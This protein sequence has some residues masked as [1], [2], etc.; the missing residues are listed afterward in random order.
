MSGRAAT[1]GDQRQ[2]GPGSGGASR[3]TPNRSRNGSLVTIKYWEV[4]NHHQL[5]KSDPF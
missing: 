4:H 3:G 1:S 2:G 5:A